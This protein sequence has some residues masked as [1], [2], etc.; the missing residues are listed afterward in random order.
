LFKIVE[1]GYAPSL[2]AAREMTA[3]EVFQALWRIKFRVE[4]ESTYW[5]LNK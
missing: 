2:A 1:G 5:E 4:Y 3:R